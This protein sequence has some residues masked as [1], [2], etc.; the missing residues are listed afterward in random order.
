M[1]LTGPSSP[2]R[3]TRPADCAVLICAA[4]ACIDMRAASGSNSSRTSPT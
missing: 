3:K 2:T 1:T 4:Q